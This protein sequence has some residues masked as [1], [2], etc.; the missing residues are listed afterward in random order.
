MFLDALSLSSSDIIYKRS[1]VLLPGVNHAFP[2]QLRLYLQRSINSL[3]AGDRLL[4]SVAKAKLERWEPFGISGLN[5]V[6]S[7]EASVAKEVKM[8][9]MQ[10]MR[11]KIDVL[12]RTIEQQRLRA[13]RDAPRTGT[14]GG[15]WGGR[16]EKQLRGSKQRRLCWAGSPIRHAAD[17]FIP[18]QFN[19]VETPEVR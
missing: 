16:E 18:P 6:P 2:C 4:A 9:E 15:Q 17:L 1:S 19:P 5:G 12:E 14:E 3:G 10:E 11:E 7:Q 8:Q 13:E